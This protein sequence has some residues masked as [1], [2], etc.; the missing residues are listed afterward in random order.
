M[1][2]LTKLALEQARNAYVAALSNLSRQQQRDEVLRM[3]AA[4]GLDIE[5]FG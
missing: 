5:D 1:S 3:M 2:T 4:L